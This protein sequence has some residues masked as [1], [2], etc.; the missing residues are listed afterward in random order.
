MVT[1]DSGTRRRREEI[2]ETASSLFSLHGYRATSVRDI[3]RELDLQGG[4]LY[5]H[6]ASKEDVLWEIVT[7][8]AEAFDRAVR[9]HAMGE[10]PATER[11]RR[12]IYAHVGVVVGH[13]SHATVFFQDWRHLSQPRRAE[14]LALRD[15]YEGLFRSVLAEGVARQEFADHDLRLTAIFMLTTLNGIASW[16]RADGAISASQLAERYADLLLTG[17]AA[18]ESRSPLLETEGTRA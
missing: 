18:P 15:A 13:L 11:L 3:A 14:V 12:M 9:P 2:Y 6:I 1:N 17:L 4:S 8:V 5:A 16:Y 10:G 7:R